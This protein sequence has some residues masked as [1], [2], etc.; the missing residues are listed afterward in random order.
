MD[1]TEPR[2][3]ARPA[4]RSVSSHPAR[5]GSCEPFSSVKSTARPISSAVLLCQ[6]WQRCAY[7]EIYQNNSI[8][9]TTAIVDDY[10]EYGF[11]II[12]SRHARNQCHATYSNAGLFTCYLFLFTIYNSRL[13][14]YTLTPPQQNLWPDSG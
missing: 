2:R 11:H 4:P 7:R 3:I 6:H 10:D 5:A 1:V 13:Q 8:V 12:E 14:P 9:S